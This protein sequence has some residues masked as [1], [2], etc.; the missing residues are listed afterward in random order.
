MDLGEVEGRLER[1]G[2]KKRGKEGRERRGRGKGQR[3]TR[4]K[5]EGRQREAIR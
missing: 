5:R 1:V 4:E 2:G 3:E